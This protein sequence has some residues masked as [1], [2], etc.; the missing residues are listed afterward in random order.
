MKLEKPHR[1]RI[2][3]FLYRKYI[4]S[5]YIKPQG[6]I[7]VT[8]QFIFLL[9]PRIM[10]C[11]P[12]CDSRCPHGRR[13]RALRTTGSP[14]PSYCSLRLDYSY[15]RWT[16]PT[17]PSSRPPSPERSCVSQAVAI[18]VAAN[19]AATKASTQDTTDT[20]VCQPYIFTSFP[21]LEADGN[22]VHR[23]KEKAAENIM[24]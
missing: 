14:L 15:S 17:P 6:I 3:S 1:A 21:E 5:I 20:E 24:Y 18:E 22:L 7:N 19:A 16:R 2:A 11:H 10:P 9:S 8:S 13:A 4:P 12:C 23:G